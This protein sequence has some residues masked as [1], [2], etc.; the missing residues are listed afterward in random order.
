MSGSVKSSAGQQG[1]YMSCQP[2]IT[3]CHN[4]SS[5]LAGNQPVL[6]MNGRSCT[7]VLALLYSD[8]ELADVKVMMEVLSGK[9][10]N[11]SATVTIVLYKC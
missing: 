7:V 9:P 1:A 3:S 11:S 6:K 4:S 5:L 2:L 10:D 8:H